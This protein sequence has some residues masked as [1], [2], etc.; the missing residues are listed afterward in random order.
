M[1]IY[2]LRHGEPAEF[3]HDDV[4][5]PLSE[6]GEQQAAVVGNALRK[7]NIK[8]D[9]IISSPYSRAKR[10]AEII[11]ETLNVQNVTSSE[12]LVPGSDPRQMVSHLNSTLVPSVLLVGHEPQLR[13]FLSLLLS[14]S[15]QT[16]VLFKKGSMANVTIPQPVAYGKGTLQWLLTNEQMELF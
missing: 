8:L 2:L 4:T 5:R 11:R 9:S 6:R 7:L 13:S 14:N 3:A 15:T 12:F 1:Q 10:T 16:D